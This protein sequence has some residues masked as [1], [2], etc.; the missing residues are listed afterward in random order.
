MRRIR[1]A[2]GVVAGRRRLPRLARPAAPLPP[3]TRREPPDRPAASGKEPIQIESDKL[4][5]REAENMAIFT[6]NVNVDAGT[7]AAEVRQA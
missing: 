6:G 5:V 4:E 1:N 3:R 2:V 7:D